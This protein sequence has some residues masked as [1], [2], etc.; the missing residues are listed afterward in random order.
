ME[1]DAP[2]Y[3]SQNKV[4]IFSKEGAVSLAS[5]ISSSQV[6]PGPSLQ[7]SSI[8]G[9]CPDVSSINKQGCIFI[10]KISELKILL[11][12]YKNKPALNMANSPRLVAWNSCK[13]EY[14][15]ADRLALMILEAATRLFP[16][17][18]NTRMA[19]P[20]IVFWARKIQW[21]MMYGTSCPSYS[22]KT[23]K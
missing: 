5:S 17:S 23:Q 9:G 16:G 19:W 15:F 2:V 4:Q 10:Y 12:S 6:P 3:S 8:R 1:Y 13:P 22:P 21:G 18:Q 11:C 14:S 20:L 7:K